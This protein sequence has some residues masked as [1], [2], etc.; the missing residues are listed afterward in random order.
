MLPPLKSFTPTARA[1]RVCRFL[2]LV[3]IGSLFAASCLAQSGNW[4]VVAS[5]LNNPRGLDFAPNGALF[6]AEAGM[7]GDG[8]T[9]TRPAPMPPLRFGLSGSVTRVFNGTQTRIVTGLPSLAPAGG[10]S[11]FGPSD[12]SF[13][14]N[15]NAAFTVGLGQNPSVRTNLIAQ[16]AA[17]EAMGTL[18]QL[19][20]NGKIKLVADL[21]AFEADN[22]PDGH[23]PDSNPNG[24]LSDRN[25]DYITDA[26]ANALLE[27]SVSGKISVVAIFPNRPSPSG[28][29]M[30]SVPTNVVR[31]PDGAFYVSELTGFPFPAG[32]ARI[33]RVVPGSLPTIY[34]Q[35]FTNVIDLEFDPQGNLYVLEIDQNGLSTPMVTGRLARINASNQTVVTIASTGLVMPGGMAIGPDGAI[36]VSNFSTAVGVGEVIRIQP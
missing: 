20:Q 16:G 19:N 17:A 34:A 26:G 3:S 22:D 11:A 5:G 9:V 23:G 10:A 18:W 33:Y 24:V 15:G 13:G 14:Q 28:S 12:I 4:T 25:A 2:A 29:P 31:G 27:V 35:G 6:I 7:G 1:Q 21:A 36:Y 30:Q 32:A 8:P